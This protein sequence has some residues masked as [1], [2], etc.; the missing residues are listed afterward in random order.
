M[1]THLALGCWMMTGL[2]VALHAQTSAASNPANTL[3]QINGPT[4]PNLA[5]P[6]PELREEDHD[7]AGLEVMKTY[8]VPKTISAFTSQSMFYTDNAFLQRNSHISSFGY[9]GRFGLNYVPWSTRDWTPSINFAYQI[10][11]YDR[12]SVLDFE[13]MTLSFGSKY[14]LTKDGT[15]SITNSYSLQQLNTP[16]L[17]LGN[18]YNESFFD[19]GINYIAQLSDNLYFVGSGEVG[20]RLTDPGYYSRVDTSLLFSLIYAPISTVRVQAYVRPAG[21]FYTNDDE[22]D[23]NTGQLDTGRTRTDFNLSTGLAATY[24]PIEQVS[25]TANLN[26]TGN[27]SNVGFREYGAYTPMLTLSGSYSF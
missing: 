25:L 3:L 11:R 21:N 5:M 1:K 4:G 24:A 22:P 16:R 8:P 2:A 14:N 15:W 20:W 26:W 18:F 27:Y 13:A 9:N 19:N 23:F 17:Q 7:L 6:A 10:V 12:T